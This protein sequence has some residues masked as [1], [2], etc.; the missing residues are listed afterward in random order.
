M[1]LYVYIQKQMYSSLKHPKTYGKNHEHFND[2][3]YF[4]KTVSVFSQKEG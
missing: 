4:C 1:Y 2:S 3:I